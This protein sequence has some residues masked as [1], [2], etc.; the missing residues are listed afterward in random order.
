M[1]HYMFETEWVITAPIEDVFQVIS[2]PEDYSSWWPHVQESR[3]VG[4]GDSDGV[5]ATAFYT[6]K[7]PWGYRMRFELKTI[8]AEKPRQI[9]ALVR[10][11]LIG[12]G[13]H[14]LEPRPEGTLVRLHWYVS[15]AK[16]WMNLI[17]PIARPAFAFAHRYVMYEGCDAMA[18]KL[19][20]RLLAAESRMVDSPS[21]LPV[22]Q[23]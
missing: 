17:A 12:T 6:I 22:P 14:F 9:H 13:T 20:A 7:S 11:D 16:R 5:G 3:L 4:G 10:G 2:H 8:E 15:T 19:G 18:K 23:E 21:P 1:A